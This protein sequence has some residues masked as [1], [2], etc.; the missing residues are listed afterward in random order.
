MMREKTPGDF[1]WK[2]GEVGGTPQCLLSGGADLL[3]GLLG[4]AKLCSHGTKRGEPKG[5]IP[6]VSAASLDAFREC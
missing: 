1:I 5:R 3:D 4:P 2:Q 6:G